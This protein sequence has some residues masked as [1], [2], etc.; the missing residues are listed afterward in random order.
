M[1]TFP[2]LFC[3]FAAATTITQAAE[4]FK[5]HTIAT[6]L[7][8]GYQVVATDVNGD[9]RTDL[10]A[11][12]SGMPDLVWF[13]APNWEQRTLARNLP[14][15]IN[16]AAADVDGDR[17]PEIL[18]AY[19]FA[20][21]AAKS[22]GI[23]ALL[24]HAGDP[25]KPWKVREIDRLTTSHRLRVASL[26]GETVFINAP[27]TGANAKAPDYRDHVP[28]VLYR[29]GVWKRELIGAA[30][31]GVVHGLWVGKWKKSD[32]SDSILTASFQGIFRYSWVKGRWK[33][34]R[35]TSGDPAPW[36]K[37]GSSEVSPGERSGK[38]PWFA[39]LEPWHG[40]QVVIYDRGKRNVIDT[41]LVDGHV[42]LTADMNGD[43]KSEVLAGYRGNG[44]SVYLYYRSGKNKW[45]R[46]IIDNGGI[47]AAG[48]AIAD[49]N[50]D[51]RPDIA[52]IGSATA[53]LKWYENLGRHP[54]ARGR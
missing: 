22:T 24:T 51:G 11:L 6:G 16:L 35:L 1:Q 4:S 37:S 41:Q 26:N 28:L 29:P 3:L 33:R 2:A 10:I 49:L 27:L 32:A 36:P 20:N 40:N 13:E 42:L 50:S 15:M 17:I 25:R 23:V 48:C 54:N 45:T 18:I 31:E 8:G 9:G 53:N 43:G 47:A 34:V 30:D 5:P 12:A 14:R 7:R 52:C 19:E 21:E 38:D 44:R 46:D 39:S